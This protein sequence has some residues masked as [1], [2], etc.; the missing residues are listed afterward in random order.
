MGTRFSRTY[1]AEFIREQPALPA[2]L[3]HY[4]KPGGKGGREGRIVRVKPRGGDPWIGVF[5]SGRAGGTDRLLSCPSPDWLCVVSGNRAY[6]V[7]TQD[8]DRWELVKGGWP[9]VQVIPA[10]EA[11]LLLFAGDTDIEAWGPNGIAWRSARLSLDGLRN[12]AV[13]GMMLQGEGWNPDVWEEFTLDLGSGRHDGGPDLAEIDRTQ[14][15]PAAW[16]RL[17][18]RLGMIRQ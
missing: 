11:K 4:D 13:K 2:A 7:D 8:P 14:R 1:E 16:R 17:L 6:L 15:R 9:V 3:W 18:V 5:A 10:K 12:L